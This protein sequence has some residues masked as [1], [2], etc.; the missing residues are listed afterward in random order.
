MSLKPDSSLLWKDP[1][2]GNELITLSQVYYD[3]TKI[4][5]DALDTA[6]VSPVSLYDGAIIFLK[7]LY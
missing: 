3:C 1:P 5:E 7:R 2:E 6:Q 4:S